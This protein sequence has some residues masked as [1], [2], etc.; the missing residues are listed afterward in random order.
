MTLI[1]ISKEL[2]LESKLTQSPAPNPSTY[3]SFQ[4]AQEFLNVKE[5]WLR[6]AVFKREIP[7]HKFNRLIRFEVNDLLL[8]THKNKVLVLS[9]ES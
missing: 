7:H 5:S 8:W 3:L 9:K 1:T 6:N 4:E 2:P